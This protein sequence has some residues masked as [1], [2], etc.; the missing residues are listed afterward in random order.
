MNLRIC[1]TDAEPLSYFWHKTSGK[2][3]YV[4]SLCEDKKH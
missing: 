1:I 4:T 2:M 3:Q